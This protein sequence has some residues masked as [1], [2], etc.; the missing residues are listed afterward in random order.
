MYQSMRLIEI[1]GRSDVL[2]DDSV[3]LPWLGHAIDLG[4]EQHRNPRTIQFSSQQHYSGG[5][6]TVAKEN[7]A[8]PRLFLFA[9]N[10]VL[11]QV[12]EIKNRLVGRLAAAVFEYLDVGI[13]RDRTLYLL[14]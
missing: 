4:G 7:D 14:R 9:E 1:H 5:S 2:G 3:I 10:A 8:R 11:V 13:F 12:E 6:P